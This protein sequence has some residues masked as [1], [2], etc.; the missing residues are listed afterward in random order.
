MAED[1]DDVEEWNALFGDEPDVPPP[2]EVTPA[3]FA[4]WRAPRHGR[5]NPERMDNPVWAWLI[6]SRNSVYRAASYFPGVEAEG[7]CWSFARFGQSETALPDGRKVLIG[8]EHEDSYD[9]DFFIYN[10]VV[11]KHPGGALDIYGYPKEAFAP[12]DF[13]TATLDGARIIIVGA[14]GNPDERTPGVT[15][16]YVPD[17]ATFA[18]ARTEC[19]GAAPGWLHRHKAAFDAADNAIVVTSGLIDTGDEERNL[20]ENIDDWKLHLG[21]WRWERLT[22]R[23]WPRWDVC[24]DDRAMN[25]MFDIRTLAYWTDIED[26]ERAEE[27]AERLKEELGFAP[28]LDLLAAL[29]DPPVRHEKL[30]EVEDEYH[31][32]RIAVNGV[33]VR[34]E[35][36]MWY[37]RLTIEGDLPAT[38]VEALTSDLL[39]KMSALEKKRYELIRL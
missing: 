27:A 9:R 38:T 28:D 26:R 25:A 16:V 34:Y 15:Q 12:T 6:R 33:T 35:E 29:Y 4:R 39:G 21:N 37:V 19:V 8:G 20:I 11:V 32:R 7:P 23:Q 10:D 14:F 31:I 1:G 24:R 2:P 22:K 17:L 13:H 18:I 5:T 36:T 30:P 3:L